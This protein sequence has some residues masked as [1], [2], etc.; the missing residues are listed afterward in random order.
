[1]I[2]VR[3]YL[4]FNDNYT[5]QYLKYFEEAN[6]DIAIK[7][8]KSIWKEQGQDYNNTGYDLRRVRLEIDGVNVYIDELEHFYN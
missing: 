7:M 8:A 2:D 3:V 4:M 5:E 6:L 1:M